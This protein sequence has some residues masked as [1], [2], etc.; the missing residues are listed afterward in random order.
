MSNQ[1]P[2]ITDEEIGIR[3]FKIRRAKA[4]ERTLERMRKG[5]R[6]S[7]SMFSQRDLHDL[8]WMIGEVWAYVPRAEWEDLHFGKLTAEEVVEIIGMAR[9]LQAVPHNTVE[10]TEKVIDMVR[11]RSV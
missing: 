1:R 8:S 5:L 9:T 6:E 11:A 2:E 7:W 3:A 4:V 10:T